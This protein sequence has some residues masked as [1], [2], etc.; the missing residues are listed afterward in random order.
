MRAVPALLVCALAVVPAIGCGDV[1]GA[2][3]S[4][5]GTILYVDPQG[6]FEFRLLEP[7][8]IPPF[9][10]TYQ[11]LRLTFSVVPP[12]D[13]TV[14]ADPTILLNQALFSLQF[15]QVTGDPAAAMAEVKGSIPGS[16]A[17]STGTVEAG[18]GTTGVEMTWQEQEDVFNRDAFLAGQATPTFRLHFTAKTPIAD[19]A[20]VGQMINSFQA[21]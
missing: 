3:E 1:D 7:P 21:K 2:S 6:A 11:D 12:P 16:S 20:M 9:V 19:D 17:A 15:S 14:T 5:P 8:W 10:L 13:A 4:F 18:T